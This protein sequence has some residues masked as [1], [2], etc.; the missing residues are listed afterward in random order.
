MR[1]EARKWKWTQECGSPTGNVDHWLRIIHARRRIRRKRRKRVNPGRT[2]QWWS[3]LKEGVLG[4][5]E[6]HLNLRM[7]RDHFMQLVE[8]LRPFL[9]HDPRNFRPDALSVEKKVAVTLYYLNDQG[10]YRMTCNNFGISL[11]CLS[12][13]MRAVCTSINTAMGSD[14]LRLPKD[15]DEMKELI[16]RF[17][18]CFGFP[19]AFG[20]LD[21]THIP[22]RQPTENRQDYFCYKMKYSLNVQALCDYRGMFL[23]V[24]IMWPGS[25][26][27][28]RVYANSKLN[29]HFSEK[30]L[31]MTYRTLLPGTDRIPPLV[32]GDPAYHLLP[33]VMK[34]YGEDA[35]DEKAIFNQILGTGRNQIECAFERLKARWQILNRPMNIKL[36]DVPTVIYTCFILH[37]FCELNGSPINQDYVDHQIHVNLTD[38]CCAHHNQPDRVH[39]YNTA[40]GSYYRQIITD[41]FKEYM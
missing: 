15:S 1:N 14:Y 37:N 34:E 16:A 31:P 32:L 13:T 10:S 22:Q 25:V 5:E 28:A 2:Y 3:N 35:H 24:E 41:Y 11:P 40:T 6:W 30:T 20:C 36:E 7:N 21:G 38:R 9:Q 18:N 33:N 12:K 19:Q 4:E 8:R 27:D 26:H 39:T 29:K 17:E 23:D